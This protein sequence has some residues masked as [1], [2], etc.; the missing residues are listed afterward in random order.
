MAKRYRECYIAFLDMLG[1][2][3]LINQ[4]DCDDI[5]R[6]LSKLDLPSDNIIDD[7]EIIMRMDE[8]KMKIMSDSI[9]FYIDSKREH[10]L[11]GLLLTCLLF[12][13]ELMNL[14]PPIMLRGAIVKGSFYANADITFGPGLT[15]AYLL[16]E[17]S[18]RVPRVILTKETLESENS[19]LLRK[20]RDRLVFEDEDAYWT[21]NCFGTEFG[22]LESKIDW[23][24][25]QEHVN[26][27]L[28]STTDSSI[29]E[30]YLYLRKRLDMARLMKNLANH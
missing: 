20:Y 11:T 18:A 14:A 16:E 13:A 6:I 2:K 27:V 8:I 12:Q 29:R 23:N 30:K 24:Q 9:C 7:G 19:E 3:D 17:K 4:S 1:F 28:S 26:S 25:I 22:I 21:I 15:N 5:Y 10:A